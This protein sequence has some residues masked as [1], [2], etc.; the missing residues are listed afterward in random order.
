MLWEN[1]GPPINLNALLLPGSDFVNVEAVFINDR[2][3][4]AADGVLNGSGPHVA[5][6][7]PC[8]RDHP[9]VEGCDYDSVV[10]TAAAEN[11]KPVATGTINPGIY[12][13]TRNPWIRRGA[14]PSR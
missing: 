5:L 1:G 7:I 14:I 8:D 12:T 2:G 11:A 9:D 4:I 13:P 6:L 10:V 3:E